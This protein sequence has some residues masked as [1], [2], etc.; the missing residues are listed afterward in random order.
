MK[1]LLCFFAVTVITAGAFAQ[2][3]KPTLQSL[4]FISGCWEIN[5]PEKKTLVSEQWMAADGGA[6][7]LCHQRNPRSTEL[8]RISLEESVQNDAASQPSNSA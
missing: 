6:N 2:E 7:F 5:K 4:A 1:K 8:I 3:A